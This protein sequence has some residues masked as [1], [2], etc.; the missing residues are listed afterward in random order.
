MSQVFSPGLFAICHLWRMLGSEP[1]NSDSMGFIKRKT[2][3]T[4]QTHVLCIV[5]AQLL[6]HLKQQ[7]A[8]NAR[9]RSLEV[10]TEK[11]K[12]RCM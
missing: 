4:K 7:T 1:D 11:K 5:A 3:K 12:K 10:D 8:G 6:E 2:P 9:Q